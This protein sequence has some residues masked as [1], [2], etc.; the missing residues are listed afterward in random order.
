MRAGDIYAITGGENS[1]FG[2]GGP[3]TRG[4]F[5]ASNE[6]DIGAGVAVDGAGGMILADSGDHRVKMV[7][8]QTGRFYG[9]VMRA[10][11]IYTIAGNGREGFAGDGGLAVRARLSTPDEVVIDRAGHVLVSDVGFVNGIDR[12]RVVAATSGRFYGQAMKTGHIYTIAGGGTHGPGNGGPATR[13]S[14]GV[15]GLSLD[16]KGNL[17]IGDIG[18]RLLRIVP[19]KSGNFYGMAMKSG[20]IYTIAHIAGNG[21][22]VDTA[23][24]IVVGDSDG[25]PRLGVCRDLGHVLWPGHGGW[26]GLRHRGWRKLQRPDQRGASDVYVRRSAGP[27]A[28]RRGQRHHG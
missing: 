7:A 6:G 16:H 9:Q 15:A 12:V 18:G 21:V 13:A 23:G 3:A 2:D 19:V 17:V 28:G 27:S 4:Q 11:D 8:A 10:G 22:A 5:D 1:A 20:H 25:R 14:V 26:D 24:N